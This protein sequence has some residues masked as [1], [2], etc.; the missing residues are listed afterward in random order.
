MQV[1]FA[2]MP[3]FW[4][5]KMES[6]VQYYNEICGMLFYKKQWVLVALSKYFKE[7][8]NQNQINWQDP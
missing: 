5:A 3:F 4:T 1:Y 7:Y 8:K 2:V 6:L